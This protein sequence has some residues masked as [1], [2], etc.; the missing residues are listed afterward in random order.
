MQEDSPQPDVYLRILPARGGQSG[1]QGLYPQ[2]AP[3][4]VAEICWSSTAYD[5][6][7][8]LELYQSAGVREY[9][10]VL[11]R[12]REVRW[13]RLRDEVFHVVPPDADGVLR[14]PVFPGLWLD[15]SALLAGDSARMLTILTQGLNSPQ[16]AEFVSR[17]AQGRS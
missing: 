14:S 3:E 16:H 15:P 11:V 6:H 7:Q 13:H 5:L 12:E 10:A 2:G 4:F 8:K 1:D 17:L 9:L